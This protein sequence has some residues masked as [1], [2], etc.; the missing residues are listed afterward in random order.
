MTVTVKDIDQAVADQFEG[1]WH[2]FV[3]EASSKLDYHESEVA[4]D[5]WETD[6]W[7]HSPAYENGRYSRPEYWYKF[8]DKVN[9]GVAVE[10]IGQA[11]ILDTFGGEGQGDD[12]W[13]VFKII[14]P[15]GY[16]IFKRNGY[17][18]SHDGS[19]YDGPTV[20][21]RPAERIVT[22]WVKI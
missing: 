15:D 14:S 2:H 3:D 8:T 7:K 4:P 20:E 19:H 21:V 12:H 13:A 9:P 11:V 1:D 22:D 10:G 17:Y 5:N 16:R 18:V 6:G